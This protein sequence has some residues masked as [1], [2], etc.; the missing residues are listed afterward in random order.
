MADGLCNWIEQSLNYCRLCRGDEDSLFWATMKLTASLL[1]IS[2]YVSVLRQD[3]EPV[4]EWL[5]L[6]TLIDLLLVGFEERLN[7][8]QRASNRLLGSPGAGRPRVEVDVTQVERLVELGIPLTSIS[9]TLGISRTTLWRRLSELGL[10]V[11]R[12][13]TIDDS[14]LDSIL[15]GLLNRF[16]NA[17]IVMMTGYLRSAN[18]FLTRNRIRNSL[19]RVSP[20]GML[21]RQLT[22]TVRR[23]YSVP[24]PNS[25]WH[26]DGLHCL[27][28]WRM[29]IHGGVDGFS[30]SIVYLNAQLIIVQT[31]SWNFS[32]ML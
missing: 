10:Y 16:P 4:A 8:L 18:I 12:F 27:I 25:L 19:V 20:V 5:Y 30:R 15:E 22:T 2:V 21:L 3:A 29:V 24:A 23:Q 26:I 13:T 7:T 6:Y 1:L 17:G 9:S 11:Q 28:R 32:C 14:T 31:L